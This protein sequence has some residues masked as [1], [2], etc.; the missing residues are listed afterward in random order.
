MRGIALFAISLVCSVAGVAA[1]EPGAAQAADEFCFRARPRPDCRGF[2]VTNS[3]P[4]LQLDAL[5]IDQIRL[6]VD[7]GAMLNVTSNNAV[8]A[9]WFLFGQS[10]DNVS[11]GPVMRWRRWL[12][13]TESLDIALGTNVFSGD[14]ESFDVGSILGLVKYNPVPWLGVA[15]RPELVRS[16]VYACTEKGCPPPVRETKRRLYLGAEL[17]ELSGVGL[18]VAAGVAVAIIM[19][20]YFASP[21]CCN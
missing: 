20:L 3:G 10:G 16:I 8:G 2:F 17:G 7:L 12:G 19:I 4:Y 18:S 9:S 14:R 11:M 6:T 5:D 13:P 15:A 1:Q 21:D